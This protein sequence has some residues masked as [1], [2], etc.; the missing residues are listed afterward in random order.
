M[1]EHN[2]STPAVLGEVT[3]RSREERGQ[4]RWQKRRS[5]KKKGLKVKE[6]TLKVIKE[7]KKLNWTERCKSWLI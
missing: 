1:G 5:N 4:T 6:I 3:S 2:S 7:Q